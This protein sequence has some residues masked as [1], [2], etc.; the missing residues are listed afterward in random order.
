MN[1]T[2]MLTHIDTVMRNSTSNNNNYSFV[3]DTPLDHDSKPDIITYQTLIQKMKIEGK[4]YN[5]IQEVVQRATKQL[6]KSSVRTYNEGTRCSHCDLSNSIFSLFQLEK[7]D[8]V[9][10]HIPSIF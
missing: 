4:S 8:S 2:S 7:N 9:H 3:I 10:L 6:M 1:S 5:A